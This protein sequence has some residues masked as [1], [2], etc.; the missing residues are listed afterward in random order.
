MTGLSLSDVQVFALAVAGA[1]VGYILLVIAV[2]RRDRAK[3][4]V[5]NWLM[6]RWGGGLLVDL[7]SRWR[8]PRRLT[9]ER[10]RG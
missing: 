2:M 3:V 5:A 8:G 10:E 7:V 9:D 4:R 6:Y 1:L